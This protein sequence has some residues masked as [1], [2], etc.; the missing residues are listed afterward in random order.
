[1]K[2]LKNK[3]TNVPSAP[4]PFPHC[5]RGQICLISKRMGKYTI[6]RFTPYRCCPNIFCNRNK[7][8]AHAHEIM[9]FLFC[10]RVMNGYWET[11][12]S[13]KK[14]CRENGKQGKKDR[15]R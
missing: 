10:L 8:E 7:S 12:I 11:A 2:Q 14:C 1:M 4:L 15:K 13:S 9:R 3:T 5:S 6:Y